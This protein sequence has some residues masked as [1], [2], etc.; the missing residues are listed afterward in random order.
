M[1]ISRVAR[2]LD[3]GWVVENAGGAGARIGDV[4]GEFRG[5]SRGTSRNQFF[6]T[7]YYDFSDIFF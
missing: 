6:F 3:A 5:V 4:A 7:F 1:D 2:A